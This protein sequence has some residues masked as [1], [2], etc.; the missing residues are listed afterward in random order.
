MAISTFRCFNARN[1]FCASGLGLS[2]NAMKPRKTPSNSTHTTVHPFSS[3]DLIISENDDDDE[4]ALL[5]SSSSS[6]MK[7]EL[8]TRNFFSCCLPS[9]RN[10]HSNPRPGTAA[11]FD[12][13]KSE[14]SSWRSSSTYKTMAFPSGCS[15]L[16]SATAAIFNSCAS[17]IPTFV[18]GAQKTSTTLGLPSVN[19]PVL[20][21][22]T[23]VTS[24]A[25]SSGSPPLIKIPSFAPTPVPTMTA[26]GV[27]KPKAH[28]HAMTNTV[29]KNTKQNTNSP[30]SSVHD[31]G[32][33]VVAFTAMSQ[34]MKDKNASAT[35]DGT[36]T[37]EILSALACI[38][39]LLVCASSTKRT[40]LFNARSA[41]TFV[42]ATNT[43]PNVFVVPAMTKE[44]FVFGT[45]KDSPVIADSSAAVSPLKTTPSTGNAEPGTTF[46]TSSRCNKFESISRSETICIASMLLLMTSHMIA[47]FGAK[48]TSFCIA[49]D[50]FPFARASSHLPKSTNEIK[51]VDVSKNIASSFP[52][53]F[54]SSCDFE[55]TFFKTT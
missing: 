53:L 38:G 11:K 1:A 22:H 44:F 18:P 52:C 40:I 37:A 46:T 31:F 33:D 34:K 26:V 8:P 9:D 39:A 16:F 10:M 50:A 4:I 55:K 51:T 24:C 42:A 20:S 23:T 30:S 29:T 5:P 3:Q 36:K 19:V 27:A 47:V 48:D 45:G 21:K 12:T 41:P 49:S 13:D 28:G 32:T 35:T 54:S 25:I 7:S 2:A 14:T 6:R 43:V 15:E 17:S